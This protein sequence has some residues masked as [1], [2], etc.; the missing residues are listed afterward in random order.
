LTAVI[1]LQKRALAGRGAGEKEL[2]KPL[3]RLLANV[4]NYLGEA[5]RV[6]GRAKA[7]NA[8]QPG[9]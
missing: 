1:S 5:D 7:G 2:D 3:D 9:K 8:K 6:T 4:L